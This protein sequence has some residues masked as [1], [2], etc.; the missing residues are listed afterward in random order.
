MQIEIDLFLGKSA[1]QKKTCFL[2]KMLV[3]SGADGSDYKGVDED[4]DEVFNSGANP[5]QDVPLDVLLAL[6]TLRGGAP[7]LA[8]PTRAG[9][10]SKRQCE[11]L[12]PTA[13]EKQ[14]LLAHFTR[15]TRFEREH[16]RETLEREALHVLRKLEPAELA[17]HANV[18]AATLENASAW[19]RGEAL[20]T[21]GK[22]E[23]AVLA[24]VSDAVVARLEDSAS[25]VRIAALYALARLEPV[26]L[27]QHADAVVARLDDSRM[28]ARTVA[29]KT[30]GKLEPAVLAQHA[31]AVVLC[32]DDDPVGD[33]VVPQR[34]ESHV[35]GEALTTLQALPLVV[36]RE[37]DFQKL[38]PDSDHMRRRL[39]ARVAWYRCLLRLRLRRIALYWYALPYRPTGP[40]HAREVEAWGR[41]HAE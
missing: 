17:Q 19:V 14:A 3:D 41:M 6:Q 35:P 12:E 26:K 39:L 33:W 1:P 34:D 24:Q 15:N 29:L 10:S 5:A 11:L 30:L 4:V 20:Q 21:L 9:Q 31:G 18:V 8:L 2:H 16:P 38:Q 36:T 13:L 23:P 7:P 22:L 28:F 32:L 40:G 25:Q 37:I 27:A